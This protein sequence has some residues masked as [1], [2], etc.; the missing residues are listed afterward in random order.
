MKGDQ[1]EAATFSD[2]DAD[3]AFKRLQA[4]LTDPKQRASAYKQMDDPNF[5]W[6]RERK[7]KKD[8][9]LETESVASAET[10]GFIARLLKGCARRRPDNALSATDPMEALKPRREEDDPTLP[11]WLQ[12]KKATNYAADIERKGEEMQKAKAKYEEA[13]R[14]GAAK[15]AAAKAAAKAAAAQ[16]RQDQSGGAAREV[17]PASLDAGSGLSAEQVQASAA[18]LRQDFHRVAEKSKLSTVGKANLEEEARGRIQGRGGAAGG[19]YGGLKDPVAEDAYWKLQE[20]LKARAKLA[21][22]ETPEEV[23]LDCK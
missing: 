4:A 14:I 1:P 9:K 12:T 13:Q 22:A 2:S 19:A 8:D 10:E 7:K 23:A 18:K 20:A 5:L 21:E 6:V 16:Q 15:L 17:V 11:T 3:V